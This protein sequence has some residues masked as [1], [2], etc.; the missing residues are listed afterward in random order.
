MCLQCD[1]VREN[2]SGMLLASLNMKF[3]DSF[4]FLCREGRAALV[5][6]FGIFKFMACYSLT[7][8]SSVCILYWVCISFLLNVRSLLYYFQH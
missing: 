4:T 3:L 1:Q 7:Q 8:F 6:S 5:T 2:S